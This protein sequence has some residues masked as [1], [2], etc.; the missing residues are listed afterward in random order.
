MTNINIARI[1]QSGLEWKENQSGTCL[2]S[3]DGNILHISLLSL[4]L[5]TQIISSS[6][7]S[8]VLPI[9]ARMIPPKE[10]TW[11]RVPLVDR[12]GLTL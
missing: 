11:Y 1:F 9:E 8:V 3:L 5:T 10:I 2:D 4:L 12:A 6:K 7:M